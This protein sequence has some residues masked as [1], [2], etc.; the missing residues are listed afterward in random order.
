VAQALH[1]GSKVSGGPLVAV[2]CGAFPR[3]LVA[4]ELFGHKKGAFSGA[5]D[6]RKGAFESADGGTLFLDEVGELP[7]E[8]QPMLLR[9][10]ELGEI[11]ALGEDKPKHVRVRIIAAT[12]RELEEDVRAGKFRH[13]LFYRLAVVR[14]VVAPLRD[15][16]EDIGPLA[17]HFAE[18]AGLEPLE[19]ATLAELRARRWP[20]NARELRNAVVAFAALGTLPQRPQAPPAEV[21]QL[22]A[23]L[24]D[25]DRPFAEQKE[26]LTDA[27]ARVYLRAL[28]ERT[29]GN[30]SEAA[31]VSGL[32]RSYLGRM[33]Q[34][35]ELNKG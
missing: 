4:S 25:L 20:G 9:A 29:S 18:A 23:Q 5:F 2:N 8:L 21:E 27:F 19:S 10:I 35:Y 6:A 30:Q 7:L 34:K 33:L 3:E 11:R 24:V 13:D 1:H 14:L 12:N 17:Q 16:P 32:N 22:M 26:A 28:L 15:R 31:R